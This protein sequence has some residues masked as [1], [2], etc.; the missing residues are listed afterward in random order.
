MCPAECVKE[1]KKGASLQ[2]FFFVHPQCIFMPCYV[3]I[4]P[5]SSNRHCMTIR[6]T[7]S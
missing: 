6:V 4:W 1:I 5:R 2:C 7:C 3:A